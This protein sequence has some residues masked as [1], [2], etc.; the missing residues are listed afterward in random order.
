MFQQYFKFIDHAELS[1]IPKFH[2][3]VKMGPQ[4]LL[5]N[6][7]AIK[8]F[9]QIQDLRFIFTFKISSISR[10]ERKIIR[11]KYANEHGYVFELV[12]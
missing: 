2:N 1:F 11:F 3:Y 9:I 12:I 5:M 7:P 10:H 8:H 4:K 6:N